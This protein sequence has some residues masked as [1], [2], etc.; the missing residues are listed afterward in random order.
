MRDKFII[1]IYRWPG[2][3][4]IRTIVLRVRIHTIGKGHKNSITNR[5]SVKNSTK[6]NGE[7]MNFTNNSPDYL[8]ND[9]KNQINRNVHNKVAGIE[10]R[11]IVYSRIFRATGASKLVILL[12][13]ANQRKILILYRMKRI[14]LLKLYADDVQS[15]DLFN[16]ES[17]NRIES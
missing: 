4:H 5:M 3:Q 6:K 17:L 2:W 9:K 7:E 12:H 14:S 10:R 13:A 11:T 8:S 16:I 15:V 1:I